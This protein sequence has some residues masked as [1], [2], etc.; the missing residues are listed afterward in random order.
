M[1]RAFDAIYKNL[2]S[3]PRSQRFSRVFSKS[4]IALGAAKLMVN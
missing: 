1:N 3:N 4:F 2:Y